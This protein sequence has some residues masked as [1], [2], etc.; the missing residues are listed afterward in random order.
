MAQVK[1]LETK[2]IVFNCPGCGYAYNTRLKQ[3]KFKDHGC[4]GTTIEV[5]LDSEG[6]ISVVGLLPPEEEGERQKVEVD[7][8]VS[9]TIQFLNHE[10]QVV[11]TTAPPNGA[12][13]VYTTNDYGENTI[14]CIDIYTKLDGSIDIGTWYTKEIKEE[15]ED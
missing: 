5:S 10:G 15:K 7:F 1:F 3:K 13:K 4:C 8:L 12:R 14:N 9:R 2:S 6:E 11:T